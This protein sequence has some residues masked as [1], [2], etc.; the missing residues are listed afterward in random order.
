MTDVVKGIKYVF[1][2]EGG[3]YTDQTLATASWW[4]KHELVAGQ[5]EFTALT[6]GQ[7][8]VAEGEDPYWYAVGIDSVL[9][10]QHRVDRM[11]SESRSHDEFPNRLAKVHRMFYAFQLR[12]GLTAIPALHGTIKA[13]NV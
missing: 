12:D 2:C 9:T 7:V 6:A 10:Q 8:P 13:V 4:D 11:F 3:E 1:A 5:Y